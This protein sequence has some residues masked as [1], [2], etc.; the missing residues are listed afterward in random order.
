MLEEVLRYLRN[1]FVVPDGIH[2]DTYTAAGGRIIL[3][4]LQNGQWFR[5]VG[6]VFNDGVYQ[7]PVDGLTDETFDGAVWSMAVPKAVIDLVAEIEAWQ[8][9]NGEAS[10]GPYQS[11]SFGGYSYSRAADAV[12][13]DAVTWQTAFRERL[14]QWRKI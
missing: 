3:P 6:S 4:F 1:W 11:E 8:V 9:K 13:G 12:T 2:F 7:Y 5:V 14:A 10:T